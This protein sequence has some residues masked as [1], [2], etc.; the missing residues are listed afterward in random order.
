MVTYGDIYN[1]FADIQT[2]DNLKYQFY[3]VSNGSVQ[4][5]VRAPNDAH[6][7][8]TMGPHESDPMYEVRYGQITLNKIFT[9]EKL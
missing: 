7:A 5:R 9:S 3:P 4:F 1:L 6:I 8:L 2:E